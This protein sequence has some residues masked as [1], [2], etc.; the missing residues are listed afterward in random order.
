MPIQPFWTDSILTCVAA[1]LKGLVKFQNKN[2]G[3]L[4][5]IIFKPK[6]LV[7]RPEIL[8]HYFLVRVLESRWRA[9]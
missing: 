6:V 3:T 1:T 8:A 2:S 9:P 4:L 7:S 5:I